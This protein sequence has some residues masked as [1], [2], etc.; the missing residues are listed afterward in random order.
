MIHSRWRTWYWGLGVAAILLFPC[1]ILSFLPAA[2]KYHKENSKS[3]SSLKQ[4]PQTLQLHNAAEKRKEISLNTNRDAN[5]MQSN[6]HLQL[7]Q[8]GVNKNAISAALP[9]VAI[10]I[11][12]LGNSLERAKPFLEYPYPLTLAILPK[13]PHSADIA[14]AALESGK[15]VILHLPMEAET[16]NEKL[17]DGAILT[18]MDEEAIKEQLEKD[19]ES[20]PMA[21]GFNNHMGSKASS[22]KRVVRTVLN[23][24]KSKGLFVVDSWTTSNSVLYSTAEGM[25]LPHVRRN[26]FLDNIEDVNLIKE[27][28][29][30]LIDTARREGFAVGI[31][32]P[33]PVTAQALQEFIP[34]FK[35][36][37]VELVIV[38]ELVR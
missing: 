34:E 4:L 16:N 5:K 30:V 3:I 27:Q 29:Q 31:G 11:D 12:D 17:G 20:L 26:I 23:T 7:K 9:K 24:I 32:H 38:G 14:N 28:I 8:T 36:A 6:N 2:A 33:Y 1:F 21:A 37:Q 13:T 18:N 15:E 10:I 35:K 25:H 19:L 22:D